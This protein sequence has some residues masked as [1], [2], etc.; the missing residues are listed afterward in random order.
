MQRNLIDVLEY[1]RKLFG[2]DNLT[3]K[4]KSIYDGVA[5]KD[6]DLMTLDLA[7]PWKVLPS[8]EKSLKVG[9]FLVVYLPNI[10]QVKQFIDALRGKTIRLLEMEELLERKWKVEDR[11]LRP[12]YEML[13]HTGFLVFCRRL[14]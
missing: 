10:I 7:E 9:G 13:G 4:H 11:V 2:L 1:N 6:L 12:E 14:G 5:E 8:A 3:I